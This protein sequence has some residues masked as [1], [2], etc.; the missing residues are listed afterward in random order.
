MTKEKFEELKTEYLRI[1]NQEMAFK[2]GWILG[3]LKHTKG[4]TQPQILELMEIL[5]ED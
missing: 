4:L 3:E 1:K 5:F 2:I